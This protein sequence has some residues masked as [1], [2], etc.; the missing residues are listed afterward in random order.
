MIPWTFGVALLLVIFILIYFLR[1]RG[2]NYTPEQNTKPPTSST[3]DDPKKT[4]I[5]LARLTAPDGLSPPEYAI[6]WNG[7]PG[8]SYEYSIE[9][10]STGASVASGSATCPPSGVIKIKGL[11][12]VENV[13]YGVTVGTTNLN[14]HFALPEFIFPAVRFDTGGIDF[15]TSSSPTDLEVVYNNQKVPRGFLGIKMEPPGFTCDLSGNAGENP[16]GDVTILIY[17][18]PN[19]VNMAT[20]PRGSADGSEETILF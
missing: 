18:G 20:F 16:S 2:E 14:V 11:G 1:A 6:L 3:P 19:V 10:A 17:N 8:K 7:T 9:E 12:L 15:D 5:V 13:I 4:D